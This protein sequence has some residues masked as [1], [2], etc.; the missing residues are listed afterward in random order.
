MESLR[1]IATKSLGC[2]G[3]LFVMHLLLGVMMLRR[4]RAPKARFA[5]DGCKIVG[6]T[7]RVVPIVAL[8]AC[9]G[10][11]NFSTVTSQL[12]ALP[13]TSKYVSTSQSR[14]GKSGGLATT[15]WDSFGFDLQRTGYNPYEAAVGVKNVG[16][17]L[18]VWSFKVGGVMVHEPVYAYDVQVA[19]TS[20][21]ILYAGSNLGSAMYALNAQTGAVVWKFHVS[22]RSSSCPG[23]EKVAI[24]ETPAIDRGKNLIY[25]SGGYDQVHAVDLATGIEAKGWPLLTSW[26][27]HDFMHGGFTYNPANGLL[28]AVTSSH[29]DTSP[30]YG[31]IMAIDTNKPDIANTFYTMSGT[32]KQ[33]PSGG[34][35]W[36]PGGAS[37]DPA[38]NDVFIATGNADTHATPKAPQNAS[39]AEEVV[40]LSPRLT[41]ILAN[42]HPVNIPND[43]LN[44]FDFGTTPLLFQP[45]GCPPLLAAI[46]KSGMFELYDRESIS[47]GPIQYI[48]MSVPSNEGNFIGVPAYDRQ[49]GLVYVGLPTAEGIYQ[50][51]IAAFSMALNCT[52]NTTPVWSAQFGPAGTAQTAAPRS[53][54]S[55]ANGVVYISNYTGD[56]EYAFN[57]ATGAQLW[58]LQLPYYGRQGTVIA[59][60]MVYVSSSDG[61]ITAW[62]PIS[63]AR[64]LRKKAGKRLPTIRVRDLSVLD[65][66][67]GTIDLRSSPNALA[68]FGQ[69]DR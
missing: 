46:N 4:F 64:K 9:S 55:I 39:Y 40:E 58:R 7:L 36:G 31:R 45:V 16:S 5:I 24:G 29:C 2:H 32:N 23:G 12:Q 14:G 26:W 44:D 35:I 68:N 47:S 43:G 33:G 60:G 25:F 38:T 61:T 53:P 6:W 66:T 8:A 1:K 3:T 28:Y 21:N 41:T 51:G 15:D 22:Q 57:A 30:W 62:A 20:T 13:A 49:T 19:K 65:G 27:P 67:G 42:N 59:N 11:S 63:S 54:I 34:G 10:L 18:E 50:P 69:P 37:I 17:L 52:L 48:A 56:T